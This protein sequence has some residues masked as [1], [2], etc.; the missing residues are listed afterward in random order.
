MRFISRIK[1]TQTLCTMA[2]NKT[3]SNKS[4]LD[5]Y[6]CLSSEKITVDYQDWVL[7]FGAAI[8]YFVTVLIVYM[9]ITFIRKLLISPENILFMA[10]WS[11]GW[12]S[13]M[14][15]YI[16]SHI[17]RIIEYN[18]VVMDLHTMRSVN[19]LLVGSTLYHSF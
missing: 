2:E 12:L 9:V 13:A 1:K 3:F 15:W 7:H 11:S 18:K 17:I 6:F 19:I 5:R 4:E 8:V 14:L 10:V 16:P